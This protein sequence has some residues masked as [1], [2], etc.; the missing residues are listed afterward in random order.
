MICWECGKKEGTKQF[1]LK[2]L[3]E[4]SSYDDISQRW[5]CEKCY[6]KVEAERKTDLHEY[7]RLKQKLMHER[8]VKMLERQNVDLY[9]YKEALDAVME[10][11]VEDPQKF[12]SSHEM[13]AAVIIIHNEIKVKVHYDVAGY[14][15]DFFIPSMKA[16]VEIDGELYHNGKKQRELKRD[17]KIRSE[18]GSEYEVVRIDTKFIEQNAAQL[19][20]AVDSVRKERQK[21]RKANYG[22]LPEWYERKK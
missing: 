22:M 3:S 2:K 12:D 4:F 6:S 5:Y 9:E 18:L 17:E 11:A 15:V 1:K 13:L 8:A 14:E 16:V 19:I 20:E 7:I 10:V 21:V